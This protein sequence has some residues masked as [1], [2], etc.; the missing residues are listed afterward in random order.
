MKKELE[1]LENVQTKSFVFNAS[2]GGII[3][4]NAFD[5]LITIVFDHL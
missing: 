3:I 5:K 2:K 1:K 4:S